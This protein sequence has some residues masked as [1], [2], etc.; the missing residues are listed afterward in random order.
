[1]DTHEQQ[2]PT[3]PNMPSMPGDLGGSVKI[4]IHTKHGWRLIYSRK[5]N[6]D[7]SP[8]TGLFRYAR[9]MNVLWIASSE[10]DPFADYYLD[11]TSR[12]I[13]N[14][15]YEFEER[16]KMLDVTFHQ[17]RQKGIDFELAKSSEPINIPLNFSNPYG[18]LGAKLIS[19]CDEFI[20]TTFTCRHVGMI[21]YEKNEQNVRWAMKKVLGTFDIPRG[22]KLTGVTRDDRKRKN[23]TWLKALKDMNLS[24]SDMMHIQRAKISPPLIHADNEDLAA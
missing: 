8:M 22:F 6:G 10:D 15:M 9:R 2:E 18:Y 14:A 11:L 1:M 23:D 24:A 3:I 17:A 13:D 4:K 19:K 20:R 21:P 16:Q 7:S 12:G 5:S